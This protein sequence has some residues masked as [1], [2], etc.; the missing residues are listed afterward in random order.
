MGLGKGHRAPVQK[1]F[2]YK[3][4]AWAVFWRRV[5]VPGQVVF[6]PLLSYT[7]WNP[8]AEFDW[9]RIYLHRVTAH[10][11][12]SGGGEE[13]LARHCPCEVGWA[14][15]QFPGPR[16]SETCS[17][18][19]CIRIHRCLAAGDVYTSGRS[20]DLRGLVSVHSMSGVRR[21]PG[22]RLGDQPKFSPLQCYTAHA[23]R[24]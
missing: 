21:R 13:Y 17:V 16:R 18:Q 24:A 15:L 3:N 19:S 14:S 8:S 2:N 7:Q 11:P 22:G 6:F 1:E 4:S 5:I 20:S 12:P 23:E 9:I 10:L